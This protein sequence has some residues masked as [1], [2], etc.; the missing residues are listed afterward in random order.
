MLNVTLLSR[1]TLLTVST[2][3]RYFIEFSTHFSW[4]LLTSAV[5]FARGGKRQPEY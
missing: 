4:L 5:R 1:V 3:N 2:F